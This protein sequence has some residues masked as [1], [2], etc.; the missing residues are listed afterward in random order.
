MPPADA[1]NGL[2]LLA[3]SGEKS[4]TIHGSRA[5]VTSRFGLTPRPVSAGS[6]ALIERRCL[7]RW[8]NGDFHRMT[9][10][11]AFDPDGDAHC[12]FRLSR[13]A[14]VPETRL[15]GSYLEPKSI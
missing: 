15:G 14:Q 6:G 11:S 1:S 4:H 5:W 12:R 3:L 10:R 7:S 2:F 8:L 13:S 9:C